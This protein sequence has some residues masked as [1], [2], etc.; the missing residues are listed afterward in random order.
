ML[1]LHIFPFPSHTLALQSLSF[2][3]IHLPVISAVALL[4]SPFRSH[5]YPSLAHA[6]PHQYPDMAQSWID[7][8]LRIVTSIYLWCVSYDEAIVATVNSEYCNLHRVSLKNQNANRG[9]VSVIFFVLW[10]QYKFEN[11][12][13]TYYF[14]R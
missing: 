5:F 8:M 3:H 1:L 4:E 11:C 6:S 10:F 13:S 14:P 12:D 2:R 9:R 7:D